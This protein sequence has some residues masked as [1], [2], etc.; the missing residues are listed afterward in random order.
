V[1][2]NLVIEGNRFFFSGGSAVTI[3]PEFSGGQEVYYTLDGSA[4]TRKSNRYTGPFMVTRALKLRAAVFYP[5]ADKAGATAEASFSTALYPA[6]K[7]NTAYGA[8]WAGTGVFNLVDGQRGATY[9]D[10]YW[11]GFESDNLDVVIDLGKPSEISEVSLG[12]LQF[13]ASWI[14]LPLDA[15]VFLSTDGN[16][17]Q[18]AGKVITDTSLDRVEDIIQEYTVKFAKQAV[19]YVRVVA[20]NRGTCPDWHLGAG[21]KAWIFADEITIR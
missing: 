7:Y 15:E 3:R 9:N 19:R 17:F 4:P 1:L 10:G 20:R 21:G 16:R 6:P 13:L 18:S 8:R 14:F 12:A 2:S 5:N 11:Q